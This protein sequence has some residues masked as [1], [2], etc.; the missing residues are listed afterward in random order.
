MVKLKMKM[1]KSRKI[2]TKDCCRHSKK[3]KKCKRKSDKKVFFLPR[4][5][6]RKRCKEGVKGFTMKSSCAPYKDCK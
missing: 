2:K 5:F 3:D 1:N 6:S 4:R